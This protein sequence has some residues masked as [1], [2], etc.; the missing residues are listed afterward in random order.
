MLTAPLRAVTDL[1]FY[2]E[3]V[4]K[5]GAWL[6]GY[7]AYLSAAFAIAGT[8]AL[9]IRVAP[10]I[11]ETVEWAADNV[12]ALTFA[13]GKVTSDAPGPVR[14][15]HPK[16]G[17]IVIIVDTARATP[18]TAQEMQEQKAVAYLTQDTLY[19]S[20]QPERLESYDLSKAKGGPGQAVVLDGKFYRAVGDALPKVLYPLALVIS[21]FFFFFWKLAATLVYSV[22]ALLLNAGIKGGLA[23][24]ELWKLALIAQTPV[25]L[26]QMAQMFLPSPIP[27]FG[28]IALLVVGVYLWQ[29]IRQNMAAPPTEAPAAA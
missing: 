21:W 18:V 16:V 28:L 23:Y 15:V 7:L 19:L 25:A 12:P 26:L 4:T 13:N 9:A 10:A 24:P 5:S 22:L 17:A 2:R 6:M 14:L 3:A 1:K 8:A 27:F 29:G 20:P 11:E